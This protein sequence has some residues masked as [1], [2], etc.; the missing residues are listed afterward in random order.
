MHILCNFMTML[1]RSFCLPWIHHENTSCWYIFP[2]LWKHSLHLSIIFKVYRFFV[3]YQNWCRNCQNCWQDQ[4]H[5]VTHQKNI[6]SSSTNISVIISYLLWTL[7]RIWCFCYWIT[8][9]NFVYI[10]TAKLRPSGE[11]IDRKLSTFPP[12]QPFLLL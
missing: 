4:F 12:S 6:I 3:I 5:Y 8:S 10:A 2:S 1:S 11:N 7:S 9:S